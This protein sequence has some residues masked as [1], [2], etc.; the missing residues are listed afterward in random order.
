M[1]ADSATIKAIHLLVGLYP[2]RFRNKSYCIRTGNCRV[3]ET[4][5]HSCIFNSAFWFYKLLR[6]ELVLLLILTFFK[7]C[8]T[9]IS[10]SLF[11]SHSLSTSLNYSISQHRLTRASGTK[12]SRISKL[13]KLYNRF[14]KIIIYE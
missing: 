13:T 2:G 5:Y 11:I 14:I 3:N 12:Q 8:S 4:Y 10:W 7:A 1:K 9:K 6:H